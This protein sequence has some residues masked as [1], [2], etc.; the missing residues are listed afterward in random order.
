MGRRRATRLP[1]QVSVSVSGFDA[2]RNPFVKPAKTIDISQEGIRLTGVPCA[3]GPGEVVRVQYKDKRARYRI[4]WM[5]RETGTLGLAWVEGASPLFSDHLAQVGDE[6]EPDMFAVPEN[7]VE[8][9]SPSRHSSERGESERREGERRQ[10]RRFNCTGGATVREP[11]D[12]FGMDG[13]VLDISM[14]GCYVEM[15]SPMR[16]GTKVHLDMKLSKHK[17]SLPG[18]VRVSQLNMGMGVEFV[19]F[20]AGEREKL[21]EVITELSGEHGTSSFAPPAAPAPPLSVPPATLD[22]VQI[23]SA[24]LKWFATHDQLTREEFQKLLRDKD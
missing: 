16:V 24:V 5:D 1:I 18:I 20:P 19:N 6:T 17:L 3:A 22:S 11:G 14:S 15:M 2:D 21:D 7:A 23:G 10:Y 13:R 8:V 4:V 12:Q 9:A